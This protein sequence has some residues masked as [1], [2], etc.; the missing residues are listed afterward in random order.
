MARQYYR[1]DDPSNPNKWIQ[2]SGKEFYQFVRDPQNQNRYFIDMGDV[3]LEC[4]EVEYKK[5]KAEDDHSSYILEQESGWVTVSLKDT[6]SENNV[7]LEDMVADAA[8]D[9]EAE[10]IRRVEIAALRTA[11]SQLD[12]KSY[13]II[14][15]L[16]SS[17]DRKTERAL[18]EA[19]G[20]SQNAIHKQKEKI[21]K[22]LKNLVVKIQKS[23]Q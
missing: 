1:K 7:S 3:V 8:Q 11:L 2:M 12:P 22:I 14:R 10:A 20:I 4:S 18:A 9:V 5:Y 15:A 19:A 17:A 6:D 16:Y 21:L 13:Q 23:S